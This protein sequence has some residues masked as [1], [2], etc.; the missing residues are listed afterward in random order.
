MRWPIYQ[1]SQILHHSGIIAYPTEAVWGLG[2]DPADQSA[3]KRLL[4]LKQRPANKGLILIAANI[5]Q[6]NFLIH[7]LPQAQKEIM[8]KSWPGPFTF[9]VPHQNRVHALIH[10][11]FNTVAI[12]V[13][14]HPIVRQLSEQ[15]GG[16][17]VSTSANLSGQ[18]TVKNAIQAGKFLGPELD[19]IL[20]GPLG[21]SDIPSQ[22]ID[23][24]S[25]RIIRG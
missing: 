24:N 3:L 2:C 13:S 19:F 1:A 20:S 12:R 7:D 21:T 16:P 4:E 18:P 10:G 9:L 6:F 15:F 23:L 17:I 8:Q 14:A 25:G 5:E 22:I 11:Q